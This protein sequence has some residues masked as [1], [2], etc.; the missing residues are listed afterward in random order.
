VLGG[1]GAGLDEGNGFRKF[2]ES[3]AEFVCLRSL[4][5]LGQRRDLEFAEKVGIRQIA[6]PQLRR[7]ARGIG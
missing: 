6:R 5:L 2:V 7:F 4:H 3:D 1:V